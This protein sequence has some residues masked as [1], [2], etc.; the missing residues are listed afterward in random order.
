MEGRVTLGE[1]FRKTA[2]RAD[3]RGREKSS[4]SSSSSSDE[5]QQQQRAV[6]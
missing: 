4:S 2:W 3:S 1:R 6:D 5:Q